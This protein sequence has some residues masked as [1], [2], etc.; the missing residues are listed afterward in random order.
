[1]KALIGNCVNS[2]TCLKLYLLFT[3]SK[4]ETHLTNLGRQLH[5]CISWLNVFIYRPLSTIH[6]TLWAQWLMPTKLILVQLI[7]GGKLERVVSCSNSHAWMTILFWTKDNLAD[8][9]YSGIMDYCSIHVKHIININTS[10][11]MS[12][13]QLQTLQLFKHYS[14]PH[15]IKPPFLLTCDV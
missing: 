14:S 4:L 3:S 6:A 15:L 13:C 1:M 8:D 11:Q 12:M 2:L 7:C 10:T 9:Y 5:W